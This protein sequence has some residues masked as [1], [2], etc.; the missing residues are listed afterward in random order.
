MASSDPRDLAGAETACVVIGAGAAGLGAARRLAE[1]GVPHLVLEAR[2]RVGGRAHTVAALGS[3]P[4]DLGCE[5]LHSGDRNPWTALAEAS[6]FTV[7]RSPPGWGEQAGGVGFAPGEVEAFNAALGA[8]YEAVGE[9]PD[10]EDRPASTLLTAGNRWNPLIEAVNSYVSGTDTAR[11]SV[12]DLARY[13]DTEVNWR[14]L[15]GYGALI[16]HHAAGLPVVLDCPVLSID[17]SGPLVR[18]ETA[19]GAVACRAVVVTLPSGLIARGEPRFVPALPD[20]QAAAAGLPLGVADKVFLSVTPAADIPRGHVFGRPDRAGTGSYHLFPHG[21][22]LIEGFYGGDCARD[23]EA[24][25]PDAFESFARE[26]LAGLFGSAVLRH[27]GPLAATAWA[28]DPHALGSYSTALPGHADDRARL[29]GPVDGR[30]FFAGEATS[31]NDFSTAHGAYESGRRAAGEVV[32]ALGLAPAR[33]PVP[34][35]GRQ[36]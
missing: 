19:R 15:E 5:W 2:N 22:P 28:A 14:V 9:D 31:P 6:G 36:T 7:D 23:L 29:A 8:F 13:A 30:L 34:A 35:D 20:K 18:V 16:A 27:L 25:G 11:T 4:I 1:A 24:G 17:H 10:T 32:A 21:R 12:R 33:Q 26:E 3:F